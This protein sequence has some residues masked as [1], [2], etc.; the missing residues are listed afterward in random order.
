ML[1]TSGEQKNKMNHCRR[2]VG[3]A[4][5][6]LEKHSASDR[7]AMKGELPGVLNRGG[8]SNTPATENAQ[9]CVPSHASR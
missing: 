2:L 7:S 4:R 1:L 6:F 3:K 5:D 9:S 8:N